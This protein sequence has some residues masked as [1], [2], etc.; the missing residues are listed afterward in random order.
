VQ[1]FPVVFV[2]S[3]AVLASVSCAS[4]PSPAFEPLP[5]H[6]QTAHI[7][8]TVAHAWVGVIAKTHSMEPALTSEDLV[9]VKSVSVAELKVGDVVIFERNLLR[10]L[11]DFLPHPRDLVGHRVVRVAADCVRTRGDNAEDID[12]ECSDR[13]TLRGRVE[14]AVNGTT[15]EIRDMRASL[16]GVPVSLAEALEREQGALI[17]VQ[18]PIAHKGNN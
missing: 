8:A 9:I 16:E 12:P 14:Y 15:G 17:L 18:E 10:G 6:L 13:G 1:R 11:P 4:A 2:L 5:E 7:L 3:L